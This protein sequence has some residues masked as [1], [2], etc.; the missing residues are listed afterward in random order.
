MVSDTNGFITFTR[1]SMQDSWPFRMPTGAE[2][3]INLKSR[4]VVN[5]AEA[6]ID[7]ALKDTGLTQLNYY[8]AKSYIA[9]GELELVLESY[10]IEPAPVIITIPQ[11]PRAPQKVNA[12]VDFVITELRR[13]F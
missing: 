11:G 1:S 12:F 9:A 13:H 4:L 5:T 6:A 8:E 3:E 7:S 2:R 10:E